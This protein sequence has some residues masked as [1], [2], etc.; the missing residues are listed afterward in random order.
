MRLLE[1]RDKFIQ[2]TGTELQNLR[3]SNWQLAQANSQMLAE[4]NLGKNRLKSLQH[5]LACSRAALKVKS[6]ELE[7]AKKAMKGSRHLQQKGPSEMARQ[8][9]S[10]RA[11]AAA[12][13]LKEG[14]AEPG[15]EVSGA[16]SARKLAGNASR[17]RLLRS[18]SLGPAETSRKPVAASKERESVQR[19]KSMRAPQ[20][21]G[22]REEL[23][24]IEDVQVAIG[25]GNDR[26]GTTSEQV[27]L[28]AAQ[29]PR[30]SSLGRPIRRA[31]EMVTSYKEMPVNI[32]L[33]RS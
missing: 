9:T 14:D 5:E 31:T 8:S 23:F 10:D 24:E 27:P 33:R 11:A 20:P 19:R 7:E 22:R 3:L 4:L 18:R 30:R 1:E 25:G 16:A 12:A 17:K 32:K 26:N 13:Q 15:P 21:S 28:M 29:F 2:L 6:S